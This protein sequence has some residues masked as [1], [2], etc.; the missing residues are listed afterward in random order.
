MSNYGDP[1][2]DFAIKDVKDAEWLE[3]RPKCEV[4]KQPIQED[5]F[6]RIPFAGMEFIVCKW[7]LNSFKEYI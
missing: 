1:D 4:C 2:L 3:S 6:H 7:C 5:S